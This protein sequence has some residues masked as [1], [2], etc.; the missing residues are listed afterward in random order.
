M[1]WDTEK[2]SLSHEDFLNRLLS[3][4]CSSSSE[5]YPGYNEY[6][7][8]LHCSTFLVVAKPLD[9]S[10]VI[11]GKTVFRYELRAMKEV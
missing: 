4:S 10:E 5:E 1:D 8:E 9:Q 11:N 7:I 6:V 2:S 3:N